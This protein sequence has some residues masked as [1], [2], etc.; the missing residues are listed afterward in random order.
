MS[1]PI[2]AQ[3][4]TKTKLHRQKSCITV[5]E[6]RDDGNKGVSWHLEEKRSHTSQTN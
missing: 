6:K 5:D 3:G 1:Q 4:K 2:S